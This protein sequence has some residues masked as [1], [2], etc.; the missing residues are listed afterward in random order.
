MDN[1]DSL[2]MYHVDCVH[3]S[4][5][6]VSRTKRA[7]ARSTERFDADEVP[8]ETSNNEAALINRGA[9]ADTGRPERSRVRICVVRFVEHNLALP[10]DNAETS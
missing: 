7:G 3:S 8:N 4:T 6:A 2:I 9:F 5:P 10:I 1:P